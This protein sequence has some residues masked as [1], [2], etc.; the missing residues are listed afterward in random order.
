MISV[1]NKGVLCKK[2]GFGDFLK[3]GVFQDQIGEVLTFLRVFPI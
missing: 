1:V 2:E 3:V